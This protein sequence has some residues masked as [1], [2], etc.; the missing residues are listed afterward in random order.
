MRT[1]L[2]LA[3][4]AL[5]M[6][7]AHG[8]TTPM[9]ER[10]R[11]EDRQTTPVARIDAA[12]HRYADYFRAATSAAEFHALDR[13]LKHYCWRVVSAARAEKRRARRHLEALREARRLDLL[14][15]VPAEDA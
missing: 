10:L 12:I 14:R 11:L 3:L 13:M 9:R 8:A 1:P 7:M 15:R 5:T 2:A 4:L 6:T